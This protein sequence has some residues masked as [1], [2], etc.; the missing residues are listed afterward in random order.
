MKLDYPYQ[1][2]INNRNEAFYAIAHWCEHCPNLLQCTL[3][4]NY[5]NQDKCERI[6]DNIRMKFLTIQKQ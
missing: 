5:E 4:H 3:Y 1:I 6:K 2:E